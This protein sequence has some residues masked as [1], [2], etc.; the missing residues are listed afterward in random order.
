LR[1]AWRSDW[2]NGRLEGQDEIKAGEGKRKKSCTRRAIM[3]ER[4]W[5]KSG[6]KRR[7]VEGVHGR[8]EARDKGPSA[9]RAVVSH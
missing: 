2:E 5:E 6:R 4:E 1:P 9:E 8:G 3:S 7:E